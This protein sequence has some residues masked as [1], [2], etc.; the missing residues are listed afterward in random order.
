LQNKKNIDIQF[1]EET[2]GNI[3]FKMGNSISNNSGNG[4][5]KSI[6]LK[7]EKFKEDLSSEDIKIKGP[8]FSFE[9]KNQTRLS[10]EFFDKNSFGDVS[11]SLE[12]PKKISTSSNKTSFF[13]TDHLN[14]LQELTDNKK[15]IFEISDSLIEDSESMD[16]PTKKV[17]KN[18]QN[19][20]IFSFGDNIESS[21][22]GS[23]LVF[24]FSDKEK[25]SAEKVKNNN[26][27]TSSNKKTLKRKTSYVNFKS[28]S[29]SSYENIVRES[30]TQTEDEGLLWNELSAIN[31]TN[32]NL[33]TQNKYLIKKLEIQRIT[34]EKKYTESSLE[35]QK[36][37]FQ[38]ENKVGSFKSS[39]N[40]EEINTNKTQT[41]FVDM[42]EILYSICVQHIQNLSN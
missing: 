8:K 18:P 36:Q 27:I 13:N 22:E 1:L 40:N 30:S 6:F 23:N 7:Q 4:P 26:D 37:I 24:E 41:D 2:G 35:L 34:L 17:K 12:I 29:K 5:N 20:Q 15:N 28:N 14:M 25:T 19:K 33:Q 32:Q 31:E 3:S 11:S 9:K 38:L 39:A 10:Q 16:S 21:Q 42:H